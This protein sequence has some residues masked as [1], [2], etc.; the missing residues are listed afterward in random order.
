M[1]QKSRGDVPTAILCVFFG[2]ILLHEHHLIQQVICAGE[3]VDGEQDIADVQG[4]V[5]A[6]VRVEDDVAHG[7]FPDTVEIQTYQV[8][9]LVYHRA[10]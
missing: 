3:F 10:T 5:A 2:V 4:D 1:V 6:I 7:S 9:V 8:T